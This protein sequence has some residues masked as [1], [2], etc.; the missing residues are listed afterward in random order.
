MD[1]MYGSTEGKAGVERIADAYGVT[2]GPVHENSHH[3]M[4]ALNNGLHRKLPELIFGPLDPTSPGRVSSYRIY[5]VCIFWG[6]LQKPNIESQ[7]F[8]SKR[9]LIMAT[10]KYLAGP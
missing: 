5:K 2:I 9:S 4:F 3:M 7:R 1:V 8:G 10:I 6:W